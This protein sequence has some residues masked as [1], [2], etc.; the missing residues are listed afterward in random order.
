MA[1]DGERVKVDFAHDTPYRLQP[2]V[3]NP[4][5]NI[6]I[7]NSL[8]IASNKLSALF[9]RAAEKDFVDIFFINQ[10]LMPFNELLPHARQKHVGMDDYWLAIS[11]QR[12]RQV[13][14]LPRM[15]KPLEIAELQAH[16]LNL[17]QELMADLES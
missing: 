6:Q 14:L 10:E 2:V 3:T 1:E 12:V 13:K 8:D 17:A 16:F 15:I 5:F 9:E 11:L 7:D 4:T